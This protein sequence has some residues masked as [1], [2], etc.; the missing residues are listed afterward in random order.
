ME[1]DF[2]QLYVENISSSKHAAKQEPPEHMG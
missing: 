2:N 1:D